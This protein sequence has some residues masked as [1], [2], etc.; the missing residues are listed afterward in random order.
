MNSKSPSADPQVD[1]SHKWWVLL[2]MATG[3]FLSTIDGSI[4]NVALPTLQSSFHT[5]FA[6][7]Q[8]VVV[9]YLLVVTSLLLGIARLADMIGKK[10][11]YMTG[12]AVFVTGSALCGLAPSIGLLI[13]FRVFQG[14]GAVMIQALGMGIVT[15]NFP[16]TERG[17]AL[18]ITGTFVSLGISLGPTLGGL[19]IGTVG[20]RAIFLV[21]LPVG[22]VGLAL[23]HRFVPDRRPQG[24]QRFD[25][26][27]AAILLLALLAMALGLT[28]GPVAGWTAAPILAL[29]IGA[30]IGLVVFLVVEQRLDQPMVDLKLFRD[31]LFSISLLTGFMVFI[32]MAGQFVLPFYLE[33]VKGFGPGRTGLFLTV[34]PAALGV[35]APVAGALSDRYGSRGISLAGLIVIVGACLSISTL[36]ADTSTAGY[37]VRL[38]PLGFGVGLFQSPNNSAVMGSAPRERLGV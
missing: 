19:L 28:L 29:L 26:W 34:V 35:T 5:S 13:M 32:V 25:I 2:S 17:R 38:L 33:E 15:E 22:V 21:N 20:W 27:G 1:Y 10:H 9:A 37:I 14:C 6:T 11:I 36:K 30:G 31:T 8:W 24:G 4:V 7:V 16:P 12:M 3:T 18:G 23:V